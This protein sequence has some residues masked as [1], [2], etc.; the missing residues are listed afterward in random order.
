MALKKISE[1]MRQKLAEEDIMKIFNSPEMVYKYFR[2][3]ELSKII[4][5]I[6]LGWLISR[7]L[8]LIFV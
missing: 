6:V 4:L 5:K 1:A 7:T 3:K 2:N 8:E